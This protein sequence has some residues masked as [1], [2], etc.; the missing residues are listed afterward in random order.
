MIINEFASSQLLL[1]HVPHQSLNSSASPGLILSVFG[2]PPAPEAWSGRRGGV[3]ER[4]GA[5]AD[6]HGQHDPWEGR[7]V[8]APQEPIRTAACQLHY[9]RGELKPAV[10]LSALYNWREDRVTMMF[11]KQSISAVHSENVSIDRS[12]QIW[13]LMPESIAREGRDTERSFWDSDKQLTFEWVQ[14]W[15]HFAH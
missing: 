9:L 7:G 5:G 2:S 8:R 13:R 11:Y 12:G 6:A 4:A 10:T 15:R 3:E 14:Q 1:L